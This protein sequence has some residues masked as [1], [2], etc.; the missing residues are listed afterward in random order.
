MDTVSKTKL[1]ITKNIEKYS[2]KERIKILQD[3]IKM[4]KSELIIFGGRK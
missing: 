4:Y 1:I 2:Y 3:L